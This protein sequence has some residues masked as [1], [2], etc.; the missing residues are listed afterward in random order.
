[1]LAAARLLVDPVDPA[2]IRGEALPDQLGQRDPRSATIE[3]PSDKAEQ[4]SVTV[5]GC[6]T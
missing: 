4:W 6:T 3:M 2:T 1:M 5:T